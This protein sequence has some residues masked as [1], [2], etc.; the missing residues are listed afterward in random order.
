M[1]DGDGD[2]TQGC[3]KL[4]RVAKPNGSNAES[5][6]EG[7]AVQHGAS[8]HS[9]MMSTLQGGSG[10]GKSK[11]SKG[12]CLNPVD[13]FVQVRGGRNIPKNFGRHIMKPPNILTFCCMRW[14]M[15]AEGA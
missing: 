1:G 14:D 10:F 9:Y 12:G 3:L 5:E 6:K 4:L 7:N 8:G 13:N 11:R 2:E 15:G